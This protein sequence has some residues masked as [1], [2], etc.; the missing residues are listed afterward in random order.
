LPNFR[1]LDDLHGRRD[2]SGGLQLHC[3]AQMA[4]KRFNDASLEIFDDSG[5]EGFVLSKSCENG[6]QA[7]VDVICCARI[8]RAKVMAPGPE[9]E[10]GKRAMLAVQK[11]EFDGVDGQTGEHRRSEVNAVV[12]EPRRDDQN[13]PWRHRLAPSLQTSVARKKSAYRQPCAAEYPAGA[14]RTE[15]DPRLKATSPI[16]PRMICPVRRP[17]PIWTLG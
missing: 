9:I 2:R 3:A 7:P 4:R 1:F 11:R 10:I 15:N 8:L 5:R 13:I 17:L 14:D 16:A 6:L 12:V